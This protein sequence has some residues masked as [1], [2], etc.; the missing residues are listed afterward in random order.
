MATALGISLAK[1][2]VVDDQPNAVNALATLLRLEGY[3]DVTTTTDPEVVRS[4][5]EL[6]DYD[7]I[8]LD[9]R[10]PALD[11]LAVMASLA[12]IER[13]GYL[14]VIAITGF[15]ALNVQ[16]LRAGARDF[17]AKPFDSAE[18]LTRVRNMLELRLLHK[19]LE[20][21]AERHRVL[22]LHDELT[23]LP[24]RRLLEDRIDQAIRE[25]RRAKSQFGLMY[26]DLDGFK[27]VNDTHG[28]E[29]GD[30]VLKIVAERLLSATRIEDIVARL[31]GDEFVVV[32][33]SLDSSADAVASAQRILD[34]LAKPCDIDGISVGITGSIGLC[35]YPTN[36]DDAK[37]LM[38]GADAAL[39]AA[40]RSSKN[41]CVIAPPAKV[42]KGTGTLH[43]PP[44]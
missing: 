37:S 20:G 16:A 41:C 13:H 26:L 31:S 12:M 38:T 30:G 36:G 22:A 23:G 7:L 2:L 44:G 1:I 21:H 14:P 15:A 4:L 19:A 8:L 35:F 39:Y 27:A 24:N 3:T 18:L 6:H 11:G 29:A 42:V 5:H 10:M 32:L 33:T 28:H 25:A 9:I 40:K 43:A 34:S 17:M